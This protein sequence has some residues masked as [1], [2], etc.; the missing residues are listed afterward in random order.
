[1][2]KVYIKHIFRFLWKMVE[3]MFFLDSEHVG[4]RG[5]CSSQKIY[6]FYLVGGSKFKWGGGSPLNS[7][8][9][10]SLYEINKNQIRVMLEESSLLKRAAV[11]EW[12]FLEHHT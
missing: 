1:M 3:N 10:M 2:G 5:E 4:M 6:Y 9:R 7:H 11:S 8:R 12:I